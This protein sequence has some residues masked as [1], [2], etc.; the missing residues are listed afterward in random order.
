MLEA[1][2]IVSQHGC[3]YV[4]M[5]VC[6]YVCLS[7]SLRLNIGETMADIGLFPIGSP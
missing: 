6:M 3:L 2:L 4:G 1:L 7:T 5:Y